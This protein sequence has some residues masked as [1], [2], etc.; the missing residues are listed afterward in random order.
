M[1]TRDTQ[2]VNLVTLMPTGWQRVYKYFTLRWVLRYNS[3]YSAIR[4]FRGRSKRGAGPGLFL[5]ALN[6]VHFGRWIIVSKHP[7]LSWRSSGLPR[8]DGQPKE[9]L[10]YGVM[11]FTSNFD[12]D[13]PP[14]VDT[15][16]EA[17]VDE[18]GVF[19][20]DMPAWEDPSSMGF[21]GFFGLVDRRTI[22]HDHYYAAFPR[23]ATADIKAALTVDRSVR[24]FHIQTKGSSDAEWNHAY[25]LLL[26]RLQHSLGTIDRPA[27]A[28]DPKAFVKGG[29]GHIGLTLIAPVPTA[30]VADLRLTI[31][32]LG[33]G[34]VSP[35]ASIAGTH[36][37]RLVV[38]DEIVYRDSGVRLQS[39]YLLMSV[40]ADG[41]LGDAYAWLSELYRDWS[42]PRIGPGFP[43]IDAIWGQCYGF[44]T[45]KT[46]EEFLTYMKR[47]SFKAVVPFA[48]YPRTSL[49]D[50]HR[51]V[52]THSWFTDLAFSRLGSGVA[53]RSDFVASISDPNLTLPVDP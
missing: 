34:K 26:R 51:A 29:G 4:R 50:V 37:A 49:W 36:F 6:F 47:T 25:D 2:G 45:G 11:L 1:G 52:R 21:E 14:Y 40:D 15:F 33:L 31:R 8:F 28:T 12:N 30:A 46:R 19:W 43:S 53:K 48:D 20:G 22:D 24:S 23:L 18:L 35:F 44:G 41:S 17:A 27:K 13:W 9:N 7:I 42:T 5:E 38:I 32:S 10:G 16:M 3:F 39:G